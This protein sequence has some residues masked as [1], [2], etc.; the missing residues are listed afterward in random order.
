MFLLVSYAMQC[1][2][3]TPNILLDHV[4]AATC[5]W[6]PCSCASV[7]AWMIWSRVNY[8]T[9][10]ISL[11]NSPQFSAHRSYPEHPWSASLPSYCNNMSPGLLLTLGYLG[12]LTSRSQWTP[13][14]HPQPSQL[15]SCLASVAPAQSICIYSHH[16]QDLQIPASFSLKPI[17]STQLNI[18]SELPC[19]PAVATR[20]SAMTG[21]CFAALEKKD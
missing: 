11:K 14:V 21:H 8:L 12:D 17:E 19:S 20:A 9:S 13:V 4:Q 2:S 5:A 16:R 3:W 15:R 7:C 18:P 10:S 1:K 6:A